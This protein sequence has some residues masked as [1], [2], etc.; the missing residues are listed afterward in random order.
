MVRRV[1][2]PQLICW[3][4]VPN[5]PH[6]APWFAFE[7]RNKFIDGAS[8]RPANY[9]VR[10]GRKCISH[11]NHNKTL[12]QCSHYRRFTKTARLSC[13][14]CRMHVPCLR[15]YGDTLVKQSLN[16]RRRLSISVFVKLKGLYSQWR[17][18]RRNFLS[19]ILLVSPNIPVEKIQSHSKYLLLRIPRQFNRWSG[20]LRQNIS[21]LN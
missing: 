11:G 15:R 13:N 9:R 8:G 3:L 1:L 16:N 14:F 21:V 2:D 5:H 12:A 20:K 17:A 7:R 4:G 6:S 10:D 18:P 19:L